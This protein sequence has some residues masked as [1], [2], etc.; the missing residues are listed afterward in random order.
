MSIEP[1]TLAHFTKIPALPRPTTTCIEALKTPVFQ[2]RLFFLKKRHAALPR[3]TYPAE[4]SPPPTQTPSNRPGG[5]GAPARPLRYQISSSAAPGSAPRRPSSPR[6]AGR[7][8]GRPGWPFPAGPAPA[9]R[10][11]REAPPTDALLPPHG[12]L[13]TAAGSDLSAP[14][15]K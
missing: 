8:P 5:T 1:N 4:A 11:D 13:R 2:R 15:R 9:A 10:A 3:A 14:D 6:P 7:S 12:T